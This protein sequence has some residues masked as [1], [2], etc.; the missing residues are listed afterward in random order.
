M[1]LDR[2]IFSPPIH[3]YTEGVV[4]FLKKMCPHN[5]KNKHVPPTNFHE[6]KLTTLMEKI[7]SNGIRLSMG[8]DRTLSV[9]YP[10]DFADSELQDLIRAFKPEIVKHLRHANRN[11]VCEKCGTGETVEVPIHAG[12]SI[13][14]DCARCGRFMR[15]G[16]WYGKTNSL[17]PATPKAD[18]PGEF[19]SR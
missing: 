7:R 19:Q 11:T 15:F 6:M 5:R 8:S 10:A 1:V 4:T 2:G 3:K 18:G 14:L 16:T 12:R 9:D 17:E 13:R